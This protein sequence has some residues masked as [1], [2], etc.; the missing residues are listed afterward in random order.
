MKNTI[1]TAI[2]KKIKISKKE[3]FIRSDFKKIADY[4]QVGRALKELASDGELI[5]VGYGL[6]AKARKNRISGKPMVAAA[7]GFRQVAE[8]SLKRLKVKWGYDNATKSYQ[9]GSNQIP[10]KNIEIATTD[11]FNRKISLGNNRVIAK[12]VTTL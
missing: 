12:I 11:R 4:D 10:T 7:G 5:R 1:K 6:Y 9:K 8:E 3:V 2:F